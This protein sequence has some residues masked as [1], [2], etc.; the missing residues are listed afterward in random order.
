MT[1]QEPVHATPI[2]RARRLG[3]WAGRHS[4]GLPAWIGQ[5]S[6]SRGDL[7][8]DRPPPGF[9]AG[10]SDR[11]WLVLHAFSDAGESLYVAAWTGAGDPPPEAGEPIERYSESLA[12][13]TILELARTF[14]ELRIV[15]AASNH[16]E[17]F[18]SELDQAY[19]T[20]SLIYRM[21]RAAA[22]VNDPLD[23]VREGLDELRNLMDY[24]WSCVLLNDEP[25][26]LQQLAGRSWWS[27][28]E[29]DGGAAMRSLRAF[30][31]DDAN[32]NKSGVLLCD[33]PHLAPEFVLQ[34]ISAGGTGLGW[35]AMGGKL[36]TGSGPATSIDSQAAE[37][38]AGCVSNVV[39]AIRL[40]Q[41]QER[42][43]VGTLLALSRA[44]DAKD[45]YT[46]GHS[47][48][49]AWL[50]SELARGAGMDE[51]FVESVHLSGVLHDIG[52]I[53]VPDAVLCKPGRLTD[54]EFDAIRQHPRIG[55]EI[56]N[57]IPA[58]AE[59]LPGVLHH[60]ERYDGRGY[61][62]GL[63]GEDIPVMARV[64]ALAD[65]FDAMSSNRAYRS[66]R[67]REE[68]L[69]EVERCAGA[70]FD[71]ELAHT[72]V[73]LDFAGFDALV[74]RHRNE[75]AYAQRAISDAA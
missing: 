68:V 50:A 16:I 46:R 55:Y 40:R 34:P 21:G 18:T 73:R 74:A 9:R 11:G 52:K 70:Q 41:D 15:H 65:T 63:C 4:D 72:F 71:P 26:R 28:S 29:D 67:S 8:G 30:V 69:A 23:Y 60:H 57:G 44:L 37:A 20:L 6:L 53:G 5:V 42:T 39:E 17:L 1:A 19:E 32:A 75:Q 62:D 14:V 61:P 22:M 56:L 35:L 13:R 58:V 43:F 49:V 12:E 33:L 7:A 3:M 36:P 66:A 2:E 59:A 25:Q 45:R 27:D 10:R 51:A 38:V 54:A 64:L 24:R 31:A 48:R 47:E